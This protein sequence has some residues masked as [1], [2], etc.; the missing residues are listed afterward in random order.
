MTRSRIVLSVTGLLIAAACTSPPVTSTAPAPTSP[1]S[2]IPSVEPEPTPAPT[3]APEPRNRWV[4]RTP[5]WLGQ[6]VLPE[7]P[8]GFGFAQPTPPIFRNRRLATVDLFP[9]PSE[10]RFVARMGPV[11]PD[12]VERSTWRP[13]CPVS[14]DE[15]VYIK[16]TFWGFDHESHTGEMI[17]NAAVGPD[18]VR[19]FK[20]M[21]KA[22]F[23]IEE[24]RVV[25]RDEV[26]APPTG[27]TNDTS[28]FEC[29][30]VTLGSTWSEH[31]YGLAID[32]NPF[33]NPYWRGDIVAPE[34]ATAYTDR[35]WQRPGMVLDGDVVT[36][37]FAAIGWGWGGHWSSL[38]DWMHFSESGH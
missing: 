29:R 2:Q 14:L 4:T 7:R 22:R 11:P 18:I 36:E 34:L 27:D 10:D 17:T 8:D 32:I 15:L 33:H 9:P 5:E 19:I 38:K 20:A 3:D 24:M 31:S 16:M 13:R 28:S 21:Y 1:R 6:R 12:V 30:Q 26:N 23:P 37:A 25:R 35:S